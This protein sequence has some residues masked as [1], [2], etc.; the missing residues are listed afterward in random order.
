MSIKDYRQKLYYPAEQIVNNLFTNGREFMLLQNFEEYVGFYHRYATGEVFTEHEWNPL[1][2]Q[3]LIRFRALSEPKKKYYDVKLFRKNLNGVRRKKS[4][5][6]DEYFNYTAPRPVKRKLT[7]SE[8]DAG[9]TYRYFITKRNERDRVFFEVSDSQGK[10]YF[11]ADAGINQY[12]YET[13]PIPWKVD[14]PEYD[15]YN[16]DILVIPGVIDTNLR[17]IDRFSKKYRLLSQILT[18]PRELTVYENVSRSVPQT[19]E[20]T[21]IQQNVSMET[22]AIEEVYEPTDFEPN[23]TPNRE[24]GFGFSI[25]D[26]QTGNASITGSNIT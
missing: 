14:G 5:N 16:N 21:I 20:S 25:S 4:N 24:G 19:T 10:S 3:R 23:N 17:I 22:G 9:K 7:S 8:I 6:N 13:I 15:L 1:K 2:S 26:F 11:D 12:L 18:N